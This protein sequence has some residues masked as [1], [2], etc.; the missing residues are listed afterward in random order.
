MS[1]INYVEP[2]NIGGIFYGLAELV[3]MC[4][5]VW[6]IYRI[7]SKFCQWID[8]VINREAK[9]EILETSYLDKVGKKKGIDLEKELI[10]R[11]MFENT[12]RK[13]FRRKV[14]EQIYEEMFGKD[15]EDKE[16]E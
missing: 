5:F 15:K 14:E 16:K 9:Y 7:Y 6:I 12:K 8:I 13:S 10:K 11:K 4:V 2:V 1:L 3:A